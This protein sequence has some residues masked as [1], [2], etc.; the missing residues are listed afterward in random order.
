[1]GSIY[2]WWNI[3]KNERNKISWNK[4][5]PILSVFNVTCIGQLSD[6]IPNTW[7]EATSRLKY[8][9]MLFNWN[10]YIFHYRETLRKKIVFITYIDQWMAMPEMCKNKDKWIWNSIQYTVWIWE[11]KSSP[12]LAFSILFP[13]TWTTKSI[14]CHF[15]FHALICIKIKYSISSLALF[16]V[17]SIIFRKYDLRARRKDISYLRNAI[18][19]L[20]NIEFCLL[21]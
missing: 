17:I 1:M 13:R 14:Q 9:F 11:D 5:G 6:A 20:Q 10:C 15:Y 4:S 19:K 16:N 18:V 7:L 3:A 2:V 21:E 12:L 8:I